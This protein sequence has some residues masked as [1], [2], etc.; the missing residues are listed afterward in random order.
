VTPCGSGKNV[1]E[2]SIASII[3]VERIGELG[4]TLAATIKGTIYS[5]LT[6]FAGYF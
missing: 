4:T 6:S 5:Q 3:R 2:V 1:A